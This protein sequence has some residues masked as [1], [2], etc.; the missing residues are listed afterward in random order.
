MSRGV[1]G[2]F[3]P[4]AE[5]SADWVQRPQTDPHTQGAVLFHFKNPHRYNSF[6]LCLSYLHLILWLILQGADG[7]EYLLVAVEAS[8]LMDFLENEEGD[9]EVKALDLH[10]LQFTSWPTLPEYR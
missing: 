5:D 4:H 1:P 8:T 2:E 10:H 3:W 9:W 7:V 6:D